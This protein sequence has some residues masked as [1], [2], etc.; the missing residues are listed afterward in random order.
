MLI[1]ELPFLEKLFFSNEI[2]ESQ[3]NSQFALICKTWEDAAFSELPH[4]SLLRYF[5]H[6]LE[7]IIS[8][9]DEVYRC[10]NADLVKE[11]QLLLLKQI[12][13]LLLYY[14]PYFNW[15]AVAPIA[16]HQRMMGMLA[17][18]ISTVR[19]CLFS[20]KLNSSLSR[21]LLNWLDEAT[22]CSVSV[23][24]TFRSLA[25]LEK[26]VGHLS[27]FDFNAVEAGEEIII[28]LSR[29]NFNHLAFLAYRQYQIGTEAKGI[30]CISGQLDCLQRQK[31]AVLVCPEAREMCYDLAY[32]S[33]KIMLSEWIQEQITLSEIALKKDLETR[34]GCPIE[35]QS[36]DLSVAHLAC[37]IKLFLEENI[38]VS[39][40][41]KR[42]F[43]F[44]AAN[45]QTKRQT[46]ISAGSLSKEFYSIDQHTAA[47]V[48]EMLQKMIARINRNFFPVMAVI[49]TAILSYPGTH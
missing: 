5:N 36:L 24:Y 11:G 23:R 30:N 49:S 45:Y 46:A 9:S 19:N 1:N 3:F 35:K 14:A 8:Y 32:P 26:I 48:R 15:D 47:R 31:A 34:A 44:F 18:G 37:L 4:H 17:T 41:T 22:E 40:S 10:S 16:F 6:Q 43:Q 42:V 25:Y 20:A 39:Q 21:C 12:D 27:L 13:H 2:T 33:L 28:L 29:H 38:F 7:G